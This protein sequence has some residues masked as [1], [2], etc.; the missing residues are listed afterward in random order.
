MTPTIRSATPDDCETIANLI[1]ELAVY[2]K[3]EYAAKATAED[4]RRGL[5]GDPVYAQAIL[6]EIG[7]DAVGFALYFYNFSTFRG[8]P[9][10]YLEDLFVMPEH[11]GRGLGKALLARLATIALER[12]CG[13]F[14]WAVLDWNEPSIGF[15]KAL[16]AQAMNEWTVFRIDGEALSRL[17]LTDAIP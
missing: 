14:E 12:G 1:R 3:L 9:G 13:R 11:R 8:Q 10:I 16:G 17:A 7:G 15:Y 4:L 5:F 2:E 6:V